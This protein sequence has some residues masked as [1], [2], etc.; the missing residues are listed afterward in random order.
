MPMCAKSFAPKGISEG[1]GNSDLQV[2]LAKEVRLRDICL[3][4]LAR[5]Y[6]AERA[7]RETGAPGA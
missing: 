5:W 6:D 4:E 3:E 7:A 1:R 2:D